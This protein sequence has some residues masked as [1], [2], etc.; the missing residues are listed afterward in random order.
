MQ[1]TDVRLVGPPGQGTPTDTATPYP[2]PFI[3]HVLIRLAAAAQEMSSARR[4]QDQRIDQEDVCVLHLD[5]KPNNIFLA[6]P[7][8]E[9]F[10]LYP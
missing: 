7:V 2:E 3:W 9:D 8:S 1:M 10:P 4:I 6:P 5:I